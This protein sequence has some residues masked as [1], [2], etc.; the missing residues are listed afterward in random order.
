MGHMRNAYK[1]LAGKSE[2]NGQLRRKDDI[3]MARGCGL[4]WGWGERSNEAPNFE[5]YKI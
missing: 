1:I 5:F 3:K 2:G 4:G